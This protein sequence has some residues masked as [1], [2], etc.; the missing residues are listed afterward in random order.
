MFPRLC[1][2]T[3]TSVTSTIPIL[4]LIVVCVTVISYT[5]SCSKEHA[6]FQVVTANKSADFQVVTAHKSAD[7]SYRSKVFSNI[8]I[9]IDC[10]EKL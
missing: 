4:C 2:K 1:R 10:C 6:D 9:S 3:I 7:F 8:L 5:S